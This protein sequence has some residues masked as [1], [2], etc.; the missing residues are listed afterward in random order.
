VALLRILYA[1]GSV[2]GLGILLGVGLAIAN[3]LL[4]VRKD[5]RAEAVER[6]LPG[7]NCGACGF[8]GCAA[9][10]AA[11][12]G[13]EAAL[14]LCTVG[15]AE[16][17]KQIAEIMGQQYSGSAEKKV[18]QVHCRGGRENAKVAYRYDGIVDCN[19]ARLL[20]GGDKV[21]KH[22]CLGLGSCIRVCPVDAIAYDAEGLV[23]VNKDLCISCGKCVQVCPTGVMRW[24]PY[25][26]DWIVACNSTDKG[27]AVRKYC[28]VGCIACKMCEKKSPDGGYKVE[29]FLSRIDYAAGGE[30]E[31]G[32]KACPTHC[33]IRNEVH[34]KVR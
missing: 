23:W 29:D 16:A 14:D 32:A 27:G 2:A 9:Y 31:E 8:A 15:G 3:R 10:A 13:G 26:A 20:Y 21:C 5:E 30:R 11:V 7:A 1:F 24:V 28:S 34:A 33:I 17:A 4:A 22:G 12:V 6:I 25:E 19:A 18:P